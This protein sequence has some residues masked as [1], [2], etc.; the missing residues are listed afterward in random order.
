MSRKVLLIFTFILILC[1]ISFSQVVEKKVTDYIVPFEKNGDFAGNVLISKDDKIIYERSFG[2]ANQEWKISHKKD[3]KFLIASVSKP[4]TAVAVLKLV[5]DKKLTLETSV[6]K[7]VKGFPE[8]DKITIEHLLSH[9]SGLRSSLPNSAINRRLNL[10]TQDL[11]NQ[12]KG[13]ELRYAVGQRFYYSNAGYNLLA[14]IVEQVSGMSYA[15]YVQKNIVEPLEMQNSFEWN[16]E[17][18]VKNL[19]EGY[20]YN[21][22]NG[23]K[24][25]PYQNFTYFRGAGSL[26]ST[27]KD[28]YKFEKGIRQNKILNKELTEKMFTTKTKDYGLGW[29]IRKSMDTDIIE[30]NGY[31]D[32]YRSYL[33]RY[34]SEGYTIIILSNIG[35]NNALEVMKDGLGAI[36]L[37]REYKVQP[38]RNYIKLNKKERQNV[39]GQFGF[40]FNPNFRLI[41]RDN[42][43]GFLEI[44]VGGPFS[45]IFPES[46]TKFFH[47]NSQSEYIFSKDENGK[48]NGVEMSF[49]GRRFKGKKL[50]N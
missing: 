38:I 2:I 41:V 7:F 11:V 23:I 33:T 32:G 25:S 26:V 35:A 19:A 50:G 22:W 42:P 12:I 14:Y 17:F 49:F 37:G 34:K 1:R 24:N 15:D 16:E 48:I 30:H 18:V 13:V 36:V 29:Y 31:L 45:V 39:V 9:T 28:L 3:S 27:T 10:S 20:Y 46:K 8:G 40:D 44:S 5:Q 43:Q 47:R 21:D 4:I 6:S